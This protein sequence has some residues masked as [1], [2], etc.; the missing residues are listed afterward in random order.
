MNNKY[1]VA[2][3]DKAEQINIT[4][5]WAATIEDARKFIKASPDFLSVIWIRYVI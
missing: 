2:Y 4:D 3:F 1:R 5:I